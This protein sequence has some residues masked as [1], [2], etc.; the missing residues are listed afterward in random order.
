MRTTV[1]FLSYS[2]DSE[3]HKSWVRELGVRL[4]LDGV[5][6]LLDQWELAPGDQ[7]TQFMEQ[8]IRESDFVLITCTPKYKSR[9]DKRQ[10]GVG[11][12]GD[13]MTAEVTNGVPRHKFIPILRGNDWS[14]SAPSWLLGSVY[15]DFRGEP[16]SEVSYKD[17]LKTI[18]KCRD[19]APPVGP[20]PIHLRTIKTVT[21][22]KKSL[23]ESQ[24][25]T[26][27]PFV[28]MTLIKSNTQD[29]SVIEQGLRWLYETPGDP[30]W[31]HVWNAMIKARP[32]NDSI[33]ELGM[34]WL[35]ESPDDPAWSH[36][37]TAMMN[38]RPNNESLI[39]MGKRWLYEN[40]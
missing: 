39:E 27:W 2:W 25:S 22:D 3:S 40:P 34:R 20:A 24:N 7:L 32:E 13:I 38:A 23:Q 29:E 8:A 9:S 1:A 12:E 35:Y 10:G 11:Y 16:Y 14:N 21:E 30:A 37:W 33:F 4:R 26:S 15:L 5:E 31:P 19:I 17:L 6:L 28:W 18:H 36:V